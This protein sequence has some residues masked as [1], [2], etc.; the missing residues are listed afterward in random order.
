[1][2]HPIYPVQC[3]KTIMIFDYLDSH[4]VLKCFENRTECFDVLTESRTED[5]FFR[6]LLF[7]SITF[8]NPFTIYLIGIFLR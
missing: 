5:I 1:M 2:C 4:R 3:L 6:K 7:E 8:L